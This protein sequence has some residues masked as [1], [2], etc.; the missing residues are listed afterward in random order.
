ME[1]EYSTQ[2]K[3]YFIIDL[4]CCSAMMEIKYFAMVARTVPSITAGTVP[5]PT[6]TARFAIDVLM[7]SFKADFQA[8]KRV[9]I[10][11]R[12][13]MM[14]VQNAVLILDGPVYDSLVCAMTVVRHSLHSLRLGDGILEGIETCD[15]N[16][17]QSFDGCSSSCQIE[18][19]YNC[20]GTPSRCWRCGDGQ[21]Q[22][23]ETCDDANTKGGDGCS[24]SCQLEQGWTCPVAGVPCDTICPDGLL[25][26]A[27]KSHAICD[28]CDQLRHVLPPIGGN[29]WRSWSHWSQMAC[30]KTHKTRNGTVR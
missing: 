4:S 1:T 21:L 3:W 16:N 22:Y 30:D 17:T 20:T 28:Q 23:P 18:A 15:D 10:I 13:P 7:E 2:A 9:M 8:V 11:T 29:T 5:L 25:R 24:S 26:G 19:S 27:W 14:D 12:T 6:I